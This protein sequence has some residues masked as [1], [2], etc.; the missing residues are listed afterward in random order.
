MPLL[1]QN[2]T[3]IYEESIFLID[4]S[5]SP[6]IRTMRE[7]AEQEIV[8]PGGRYEGRL[9]STD[10]Q[11]FTRL[12]FKEID[13]GRWNRA[14]AFGSTQSGKTITFHI[15]PILY[16]LFEHRE[17]VVVG[18]PDMNMAKDKWFENFEPVIRRTRY[19]DLLPDTGAGSRGGM[20]RSVRFKNGAVL[21]FMTGGGSD[22]SVAGYSTRV[23][24]ITETDGMDK[25]SETSKE[26]DRITQI[27]SRTK[28]YNIDA[29]IYLECTV[30]TKGGRIYREWENG[31]KSIIICPCPYCSEWVSPGRENLMGWQDASNVKE[32]GLK[33]FFACPACGHPLTQKNRYEMNL[34]A[35]LKHQNDPETVITF[36][37][38]W[39]AFNN[40]FF[41]SEYLGQQE[42]LKQQD[43]DEIKK[44][45]KE[46]E[47]CQFIWAIPYTSPAMDISQ[48]HL[49]EVV[50]RKAAGMYRCIVPAGT[51]Y[52]TV[53][54]DLHKFFGA[55]LAIAWIGKNGHI[56]DYGTFD[57]PSRDFG[58][59]R[60]T[61]MAL[62][63]LRDEVL[64]ARFMGLDQKVI[65]PR[66]VWI[67]SGYAET[68]DA[69]YQF[70]RENP[71]RYRPIK[72]YGASQDRASSYMQPKILSNS[73]ML[74]GESYHFSVQLNGLTMLVEI[75]SDH[76][77]SFFHE[78]M[79]ISTDADGHITLYDSPDK[80]EHITIGNHFTAE[81]CQEQT[82]SMKL[83]DGSMGLKIVKVWIRE[84]KQNHFFDCAYIACAAGHYCG[85]RLIPQ[86]V[87]PAR[88]E[89]QR[90]QNNDRR[91]F[92]NRK[93]YGYNPKYKRR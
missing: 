68:K 17:K 5:V 36:S 3:G 22:K 1:L 77:K 61:L 40:M 69:L 31:T 82:V 7:F 72:G 60:A 48:L 30:T 44:E 26:S 41:P 83:P 85:F 8:L 70:C 27:E 39:G 11:P 35:D 81:R 62:Q 54:V 78:R 46:K 49:S 25:V 24:A 33:A 15:I 71:D 75:D 91:F 50:N 63:T 10:R 51:D 9:Y 80:K 79:S 73:I 47:L 58:E 57:I 34:A 21:R 4:H 19:A 6:I 55:Y 43:Y 56:I 23:A 93:N 37:M 53:G 65:V 12:W 14:G 86:V 20:F 89:T 28:E 16:H 13:S 38:C 84:K 42:W 59:K 29:R 18:I 87:K 88:T 52:V 2:T 74:I 90:N 66:Q 67:D 32:A 64:N 92:L 45:N 76:W